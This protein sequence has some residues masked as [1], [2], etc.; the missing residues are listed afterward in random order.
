[1]CEK[2]RVSVEKHDQSNTRGDRHTDDQHSHRFLRPFMNPSSM[3]YASHGFL[4]AD[5][6]LSD[7]VFPVAYSEYARSAEFRS[8]YTGR[9]A[10]TMVLNN[11]KCGKPKQ[12]VSVRRCERRI[13]TR[14]VENQPR[15]K[16]RCPNQGSVEILLIKDERGYQVDRRGAQ[17]PVKYGFALVCTTTLFS[18]R[19]QL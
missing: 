13:T 3:Q 19:Q 18:C 11:G 5:S 9:R 10:T 17:T 2:Q 16:L 7:H 8:V 6:R 14:C 15:T 12:H 1:M 4:A